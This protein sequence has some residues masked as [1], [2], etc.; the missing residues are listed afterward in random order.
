M[1][2]SLTELAMYAAALVVPFLTPG[3]EW[4][5]LV[6]RTLTGGFQEAWSLVL[7]VAA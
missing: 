5:A 6:V 1:T 2:V 4:V 3:P 7:G